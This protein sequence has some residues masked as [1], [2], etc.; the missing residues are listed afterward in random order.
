MEP[1]YVD[2]HRITFGDLLIGG[3]V[4]WVFFLGIFSGDP[5]QLILGFAF[6]T[7]LAFTRH[8]RYEL[9]STH[10]VIRFLGPRQSII[11]L[12]EVT[13]ADL[14]KMP[15]SGTALMVVREGGRR[16]M[17]TPTDSDRLLQELR[18]VMGR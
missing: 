14:V 10:L 12:A 4:A 6:V 18:A 15:M 13:G 9:T 2:R 1:I 11:P 7:F 5:V 17:L 3:L 16:V 8:R